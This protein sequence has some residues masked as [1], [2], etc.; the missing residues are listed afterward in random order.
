MGR[1]DYELI[2][3]AFVEAQR[4]IIEDEN[5]HGLIGDAQLRGVRR[6]AAHMADALGR[7]NPR[8]DAALFLKA[9][10]YGA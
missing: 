6:A 5:V 1:K 10:G 7:D 9:A 2:A 4:R 8:F 3:K